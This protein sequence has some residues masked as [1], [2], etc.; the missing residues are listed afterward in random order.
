MK[1]ERGDDTQTPALSKPSPGL[2]V[3]ATP[4]G[5]LRDITYRALEVL[6]TADLI[7]CEDSRVTGRLLEHYG[8]KA[9]MLA[10]NDHN[11]AKVRPGILS[12]LESGEV[13]ALVSDA[14]TPLISDPGYKLVRDALALGVPVM[15]LPGPSAML[16]ALASA[17]LPTDQFFFAG[18]LPPK[19]VGRRKRLEQLKTVPGT[20]IFY[21]SPGRAADTLKDMAEVL[22]S[23]REGVLAR[24][25]TK[26]FEEIL[27]APLAELAALV[28][29]RGEIL[30]EVVLMVGPA[31]EEGVAPE[32]MDAALKKAMQEMRLKEAAAFVAEG[33]GIPR[34]EVYRRALELKDAENR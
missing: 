34:N 19:E 15:S 9:S 24:E 12:S 29:A 5:N 23:A 26:K 8:I 3:V 30:G 1:H 21:E 13:V 22:G 31:P 18:F 33:L 28:A 2:Y 6:K 32:E 4:I 7:V 27:R 20:L 14:G 16:A 17:G 25:L 11:A 10:Y